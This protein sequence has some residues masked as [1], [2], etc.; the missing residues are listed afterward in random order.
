[1]KEIHKKICLVIALLFGII[2]FYMFSAIR[3]LYLRKKEAET[4]KEG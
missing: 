2:P 1:M 3:S 4:K